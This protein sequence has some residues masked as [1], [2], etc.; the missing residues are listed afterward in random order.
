M[1]S[2]VVACALVGGCTAA[3]TSNDW[4]SV[5]E[6]HKR[7]L[8]EAQGEQVREEDLADADIT[9]AYLPRLVEL[10]C[11]GGSL[12][13]STHEVTELHVTVQ[14]PCGS[15]AAVIEPLEAFGAKHCLDLD[16]RACRAAYAGMFRARIRERYPEA[17]VAWIDNHCVGYPD[18]CSSLTRLER[19]YAE[20]HNRSLRSAWSLAVQERQAEQERAA[21]AQR[22]SVGRA[23][24]QALQGVVEDM[25]P[26]PETQCRTTMSAGTAYT[27]CR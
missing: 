19:L 6:R 22:V 27:S 16:T 13:P 7:E 24:G 20:T 8:R 26:P 5:P 12:K 1:R 21:A 17:D 2:L 15:V 25:R 18:E 11:D 14:Q 4:E 10:V 3:M 23:I 9:R